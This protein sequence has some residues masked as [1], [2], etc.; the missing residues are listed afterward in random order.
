MRCP[1]EGGRFNYEHGQK[2]CHILKLSKFSF[3]LKN[4]ITP[5]QKA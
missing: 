5:E 1:R 4:E 3:F 2:L